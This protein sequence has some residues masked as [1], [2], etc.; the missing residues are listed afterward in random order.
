MPSSRAR[1]G[2]GVSIRRSTTGKAWSIRSAT[3]PSPE[4]HVEVGGHRLAGQRRVGLHRHRAPWRWPS[5]GA[6][7]P[8]GATPRS[9]RSN[10]LARSAPGA[11][12][13]AS[14][15]T[16]ATAVPAVVEDTGG[17]QADRVAVERRHVGD[18][19]VGRT[20][21]APAGRVG[22]DGAAGLARDSGPALGEEARPAW[23]LAPWR[24]T[25][26]TPGTAIGSSGAGRRPRRHLAGGQ[27]GHHAVGGTVRVQDG[28]G[29]AAVGRGQLLDLVPHGADRVE[30]E[31]GAEVDGQLG[32]DHPVGPGLTGRDQ[33]LPEPE[34]PALDV[35]GRA[36]A[37]VGLGGGQD[38][39]GVVEHVARGRGHGHH[40]AGRPPAPGAARR[41]SGKSASGSAPSST[42]AVHR[43]AA[44]LVAGRGGE[45]AGGGAPA[46]GGHRS[47][48]RRRTT[49]GR[50]RGTPGRAGR[51]GPVPCRGRRAR[52]PAAGRAGSGPRAGPRPGAWAASA[53][54]SPSSASDGR[55]TTTTTGPSPT[56]R[57]AVGQRRRRRPPAR[58]PAPGHQG[59][60]QAGGLARAV[61]QRHGGVRGE[62]RGLGRQLDERQVAVDGG[63]PQAEEED[64]QL[65]AD[66]AGQQDHGRRPP[67]PGRWWPGAGRAPSR[68][69]ARHPAGRRPSRCRARP[70]PRRAQA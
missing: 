44:G 21:T 40:E 33:L 59:V 52:C 26:S 31:V 10:G 39:V 67:R 14:A 55:P 5:A 19:E 15:G 62:R 45:D 12:R 34:D 42:S 37:L 65:L 6:P 64:R 24:S 8:P 69:A 23:R 35:G 4:G 50:R 32:G 63:R 61:A 36:R 53:T 29:D 56:R 28:L 16:V 20:R 46:G 17:H 54:S 22:P 57:R 30:A 49:R 48:G 41:R 68:P 70:W 9:S 7:V 3:V 11:T 47:P 58:A 43:A 13:P 18:V 66:V 27:R 1:R 60:D 25:D 38:D 51:P 2:H